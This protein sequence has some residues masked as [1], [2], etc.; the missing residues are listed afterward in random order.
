MLTFTF[1]VET[2]ID[3]EGKDWEKLRHVTVEKNGEEIADWNITGEYDQIMDAGDFWS[4]M[5]LCLRNNLE[6]DDLVLSEEMF[7]FEQMVAVLQSLGS[8]VVIHQLDRKAAIERRL[9]L[10]ED[11]RQDYLERLTEIEADIK[12]ENEKLAKEQL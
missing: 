3:N 1:K 5:V 10:L 11:Y 9:R 12:T 6:M 4:L 7:R 2:R 8:Q